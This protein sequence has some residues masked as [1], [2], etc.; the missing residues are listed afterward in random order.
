MRELSGMM[1]MFYLFYL[2]IGC[3]LHGV[4][5][6]V[7]AVFSSFYHLKPNKNKTFFRML[8]DH[9]ILAFPNSLEFN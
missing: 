7:C 3:L 6:C 5:V 2:L 8:C 9:E 1:E 4:C